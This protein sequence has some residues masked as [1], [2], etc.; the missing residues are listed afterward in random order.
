MNGDVDDGYKALRLRMDGVNTQKMYRHNNVYCYDD[1]SKDLHITGIECDT[2]TC[3]PFF[4]SIISCRL[5]CASSIF[6][7]FERP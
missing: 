6:Y 1:S 2:S 4:Q 7:I 3:A 5:L